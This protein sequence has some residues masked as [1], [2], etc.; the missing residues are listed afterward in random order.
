MPAPVVLVHGWAGSF[1]T[2]WE[3]TGF[4]ALLADAGRTV[5]GIDLLGHGTAPKPHE[6]EAYEDLGARIRDA[7][8]DE[9]VDAIGFSLGAITLLGVAAETPDAFSRI[10]LAGIGRN[11]VDP[12]DEEETARLIAAVEGR[13]AEDDTRSRAFAQHAHKPG[14]DPVALAAV[15]R[16]TR[17]PRPSSEAFASI[18]CP[19]LIAIGDADEAGPGEPLAALLPNATVRTLRRTDHFATPESF[20]FIDA[21]LEFLEA[22]PR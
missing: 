16:R 15:F 19:V 8:P 9:P 3:E 17:P 10:V 13:A 6:P 7:L 5:I 1:A 18:T 12:P 14:N 22:V 21:A 20:A 4:T 2:T 11:V